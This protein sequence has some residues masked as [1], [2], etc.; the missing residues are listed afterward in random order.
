MSNLTEKSAEC[1]NDLIVATYSMLL[2]E[3]FFI[4]NI[5]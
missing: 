2:I 5:E 1:A 4:P 3:I